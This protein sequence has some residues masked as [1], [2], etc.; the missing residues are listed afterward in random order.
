MPM[1]APR[2]P[3]I[4]ATGTFGV[5]GAVGVGV[6]PPACGG[7]VGAGVAVG[8]GV[9]GVGVGPGVAVG[10]G[11]AVGPGVGVGVAVGTARVKESMHAGSAAFGVTCGTVGATGLVVVNFW[12]VRKTTT[13]SP[14]VKRR[15]NIMCQYCF[16]NF[17]LLPYAVLKYFC[18]YGYRIIR[19]VVRYG[20]VKGKFSGC[21]GAG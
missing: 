3:G 15:T 14:S 19:D 17:I 5:G 21:I 18:F 20:K 1:V 2:T 10:V 11:V 9:V 16:R 4:P 12:L 6:G 13:A 8:P 7:V